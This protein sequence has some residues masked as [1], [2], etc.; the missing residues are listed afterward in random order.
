[1][2]TIYKYEP[3]DMDWLLLNW[4]LA[5]KHDGEL[6]HTLSQRVQTPATF[7]NFV[8]QRP[9][10]YRL[11]ELQT[12][13]YVAWFEPIMGNAFMGFYIAPSARDQHEEKVFFLFDMLNMAFVSGVKVIVG[14]IQERATPFL[15]QK[16]IKL[17]MRL[18]Y[19]YSG[20]VPCLFDGKDCHVVAYTATNWEALQDGRWQSRWRRNRE[21]ANAAAAAGR[22]VN[23]ADRGQQH[24]ASSVG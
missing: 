11:S 18:G 3:G 16:F 21:L 19:N 13:T 5:M 17:H 14:L 22:S 4:M 1:M 2:S 10:Y 15:T 7:L 12:V 6:S 8:S 24:D 23:G 9:L 20:V